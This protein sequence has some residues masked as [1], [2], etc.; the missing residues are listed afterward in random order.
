MKLKMPILHIALAALAVP[1]IALASLG[2]NVSTV[3][4]DRM[5]MKASMPSANKSASFTVHEMTTENGTTVREYEN[6]G[7]TVFA[8]AWHGPAMPNLHQLLGNYFET[9]TTGAKAKHAGHSHLMIRQDNL[10]VRAAGHMRS[11]AGTAYDPKLMPSGVSE[12]DIN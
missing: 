8:V 4:S 10:V 2:D 11:F 9:Y 12:S 5:Q 1:S 6:S 7:G 3:Q